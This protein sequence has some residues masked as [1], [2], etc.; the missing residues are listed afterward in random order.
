MIKKR[1]IITDC[2]I[3]SFPICAIITNEEIEFSYSLQNPLSISKE[4]GENFHKRKQQS[5]S[6]IL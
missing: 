6:D 1:E 4:K 2:K 3:L 5:M